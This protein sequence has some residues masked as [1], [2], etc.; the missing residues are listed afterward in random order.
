M[1]FFDRDGWEQ[2]QQREHE[3][4]REQRERELRELRERE[5]R[6][7]R[8]RDMRERDMRDQRDPWGRMQGG[9]GRPDPRVE[10]P[11]PPRDR[12]RRFF[13]SWFL[14][15][16]GIEHRV[17]QTDIP[18]YLGNDATVRRGTHDVGRKKK[19]NVRSHLRFADILTCFGL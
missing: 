3:Q 5:L 12:D 16:E 17:V 2:Q 14:D 1:S 19:P 4:Q 9:P 18:R 15:G 6:E 8:D 7:L 10:F 11:E 13:G